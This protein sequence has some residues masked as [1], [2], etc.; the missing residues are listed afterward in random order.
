MVVIALK[1]SIQP[2]S[3]PIPTWWPARTENS[4][5]TTSPSMPVGYGDQVAPCLHRGL[6]ID[7]GDGQ[8]QD[9]RRRAAGVSVDRRLERG[10][11]FEQQLPIGAAGA[12]ALAGLL[13][14]Q[15]SGF[16]EAGDEVNRQRT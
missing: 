8:V 10:E 12:L 7:V 3:W 11:S 5:S 4:Y 15:L 1:P 2:M 14:G 9:V 6:R 16:A 13:Q